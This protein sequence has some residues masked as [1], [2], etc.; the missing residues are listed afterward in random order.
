[1]A[2]APKQPHGETRQR[3][4]EAELARLRQDLRTERTR[5]RKAEAELRDRE[6]QARQVETRLADIVE[7]FPGAVVVY[8]AGS[9]ITTANRAFKDLYPSQTDVLVP[10]TDL[11]TF[12]R[13]GLERGAYPQ[14]KGRESEWLRERLDYQHS[15]GEEPRQRL[16]RSRGGWIQIRE[17]RTRDGG[18]VSVRL[19]VT[20]RKQ[21]EDAL[22]ESEERFRSAF[23][24]APIG[25]V[26]T[27]LDGTYMQVNPA[28][29]RILGYAEHELVGM[30]VRHV[31][32]PDDFGEHLAIR[33]R[34]LASEIESYQTEKRYVCKG[35]RVIWGV[36]S[37]SLVHDAE[38][39]TLYTIGQIQ[40][41]NERRE[42]EEAL[43]ESEA[44]LRAILDNS[45]VGI[46]VRDRQGRYQL[47]NKE[48]EVRWDV[49]SGAAL[50]K[51]PCDLFPK[52]LADRF[53]ADDRLVLS[54]GKAIE[55]EGWVPLPNG[56]ERI[57]IVQK[58]PIPGPDGQI[59][60]VGVIS[61]D[62]TPRKRMEEALRKSEARLRALMDN[63]PASIY[64]R[65]RLGLYVL[66]NREFE[67]RHAIKPGEALG[68]SAHYLF[69]AAVAES[70]LAADRQI[71]NSRKGVSRE[72]DLTYG[73]GSA[74]AVLSV[75]FPIVRDDGE[76]DSVGVISTDIT[77]ERRNEELIRQHQAELAHVY[78]LHI[79]GEMATGLAHE[80]NQPL[81]AIASYAQGCV[82]RLD[83]DTV[84][85][86]EL[87]DILAKISQQ[88]QRAGEIIHW[89]RGF[90]RKG[91]EGRS[92]FDAAAAIR[93]A[94]GLMTHELRKSGVTLVLRLDKDLPPC[95]GDS[96]QVQQVILNLARNG[97]EAM[98][99]GAVT[100]PTL[101][102]DATA[103]GDR[104]NIAVS[105]NG[106]GVSEDAR[107]HLFDPFFTTRTLGLGMGLSICRT[108]V[109]G[110]GGRLWLDEA[111]G[112]GTVI[113]FTLKRLP[114]TRRSNNELA[115][116]AE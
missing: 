27:A 35:G 7:A 73:D 89:M 47:A 108:I 40:D 39:R 42:V 32:H 29:C 110:H 50:G 95:F 94:A 96:I 20:A 34:L 55:K 84:S 38:G 12:V 46:Y 101:T 59:D 77:E 2:H 1:M 24:A 61:T 114:E 116:A 15:I 112:P 56:E 115:A 11:E 5:R 62:I 103:D 6:L 71:M 63:T 91:S 10:S 60:S 21:A 23:H 75:K 105:D 28:L 8:D 41:V 87:A 45:P 79:M 69:P 99:E 67:K 22:R 111:D 104:I 19:D 80:L 13:T 58:F 18:V 90:V 44:R 100:D 51:S 54:T 33:K 26:I 30:H 17:R 102:I 109:E 68:K 43:R 37:V 92:Q 4:L 52:E 25:M 53:L 107:P 97:I 31:I 78:R 93:Q 72:M 81:A 16:V 66:T 64:L 36:G 113:R 83:L 49:P 3:D 48:F 86:D 74:R 76:V 98:T 65:D 14:A 57:T 85:R 88:A 70:Y 9:K 82:R 106:P